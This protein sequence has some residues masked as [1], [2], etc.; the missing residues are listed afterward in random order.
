[1]EEQMAKAIELVGEEEE[2]EIYNRKLARDVVFKLVFEYEV[3]GE[4]MVQRLAVLEAYPFQKR[5][6]DYISGSVKG[7]VQH[8]EQ[9]DRMIAQYSQNWDIHRLSKVTIA[10]IRVGVYELLFL[11]D[12]PPRVT[13]NECI[14]LAK[15]YDVPASGKFVNGILANVYQ[16]QEKTPV[17]EERTME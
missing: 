16:K 6:K 12:I 15:K 11:E 5:D 1:M 14:N 4:E 2:K 17:Q 10:A 9:I 13:I 8:I 3:Q 7:I